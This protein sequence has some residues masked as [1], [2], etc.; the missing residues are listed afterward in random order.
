MFMRIEKLYWFRLRA[1]AVLAKT[2]G[3]IGK[4]AP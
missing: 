4:E 3:W 1:L 2:A